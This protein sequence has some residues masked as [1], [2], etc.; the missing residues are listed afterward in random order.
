M[1][2]NNNIPSISPTKRARRKTLASI[3]TQK[4]LRDVFSDVQPNKEIKVDLTK[5][6]AKQK[7]RY[8]VNKMGV[9]LYKGHKSY[10]IM[11]NV[12]MGIQTMVLYIF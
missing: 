4:D 6:T 9:V 5:P 2:L 7:K 12:Q 11:R 8:R 1:A 3:I 10:G